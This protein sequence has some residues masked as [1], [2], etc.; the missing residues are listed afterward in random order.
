MVRGLD[1]EVYS[2]STNFPSHLFLIFEITHVANH[3]I[4]KYN[5]KF[6][7]S[8]ARKVSRIANDRLELLVNNL[9][10]CIQLDDPSYHVCRKIEALPIGGRSSNIKY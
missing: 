2:D 5:I 9:S 10:E 6:A 1:K 3:G 8:K 4:R 7:I